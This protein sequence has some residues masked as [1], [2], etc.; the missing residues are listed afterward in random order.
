MRHTHFSGANATCP[1]CGGGFIKSR[2]WSQFCS[3]KCRKA[4]HK[5]SNKAGVD[6]SVRRAF[7]RIESELSEIKSMLKDGRPH[8]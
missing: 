7:A 5:N 8:A 6:F 3:D 4:F 2:S 1:V